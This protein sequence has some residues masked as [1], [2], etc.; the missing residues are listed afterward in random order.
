MKP[1]RPTL[2]DDTINAVPASGRDVARAFYNFGW[3][4]AIAD[5]MRAM[6]AEFPPGPTALRIGEVLSSL[7]P[8]DE[9]RQR[10]IRFTTRRDGQ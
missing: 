5:A 6:M 8:E 3:H 4:A 10:G 9:A 2:A 7:K 1:S